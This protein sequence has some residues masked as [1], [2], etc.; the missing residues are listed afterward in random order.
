MKISVIIPVGDKEA[1]RVC[2]ESI[3]ASIAAY[4]GD[5]VAEVLPCWDLEHQGA[6]VARNEG[7]T[8]ATGDWI[9]WV[10]C[11]DVVERN[12]FSEIAETIVAHGE[13]D[14]IQFDATEVKDGK[15]RP[16]AYRY[17]GTVSAEAFARELLRNDGMPA[18]LWT[19]VLRRTLFAEL[20][21]D[22]RVK[23]DYEMFLKLLPR[24]R[25]VW[26]IGRPLYRYIR[27]GHGLS[28]YV[29]E[30]DYTAAGNVFRE[31]ILRLPQEWQGD[32]WIGLALT[33]ADVAV[34]SK[35][36]NGAASW[37]RRYL[38]RVLLDFG[39]PVRLKVKCLLAA[40]KG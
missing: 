29:Q 21:F 11:D 35:G 25:A 34:H 22:G 2:E 36:N 12:W 18:W 40:L 24:V 8:K 7:L 37:V 39:V 13:A 15:E 31:H 9:A 10:D 27:H 23:Q 1:W 6:Y 26:S 28:N 16:L 20:Q 4:H 3:Q 30:M 17:G 5:V 38:G 14:V 32:A 19:R 33:M